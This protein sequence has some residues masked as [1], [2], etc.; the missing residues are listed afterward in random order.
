MALNAAVYPFAAL[1]LFAAHCLLPSAAQLSVGNDYQLLYSATAYFEM[2]GVKGTVAISQN[3]L[4][5]PAKIT[6]QLSGLPRQNV[7]NQKFDWEIHEYPVRYSLLRD[8]PCSAEE[9]GEIFD[10]WNTLDNPLYDTDCKN[11]RS[12]CAVGDLGGKVGYLLNTNT[13]QSFRYPGLQL[14]GPFSPVGRS[15]V[16]FYYLNDNTTLPLACANIER[17]GL[18]IVTLKATFREPGRVQGDVFLRYVD[19][20][21][22]VTIYADLYRLDGGHGENI[23]TLRE[24]IVPGACGVLYQVY[25]TSPAY[26]NSDFYQ[27]LQ[28]CNRTN[29][30]SCVIG[31]LTSKCGNLTTD[32]KGRMRAFC[33]DAQLGLIPLQHIMPLTLT[34]QNNSVPPFFLDCA[35]L[36][37][38]SPEAA[39]VLGSTNSAN[40]QI[41]V[42]LLFFQ[43][44]PYERTFIRSYYYY[45]RTPKPIAYLEIRNSSTNRVLARKNQIYL[46]SPL[47]ALKLSQGSIITGDEVPIGD[48][49]FKV[50]TGTKSTYRNTDMTLWLPLFGPYNITNH[51][52]VVKDTSNGVL[53]SAP[54]QRY[55]NPTTLYPSFMG[56]N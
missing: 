4:Y 11:N 25:G 31:D 2:N 28:N 51:V 10:P 44:D 55:D 37:V 41:F 30:R 15:I 17:Q 48:L 33:T 18:K 14:R 45:K 7:P 34:I 46:N 20:R 26:T 43:A 39:V 40:N 12:N 47:V 1:L 9:V 27:Y 5:D 38:V 23:W 22:E 53:L 42:N 13:L 32:S 8:F 21:S 49:Q 24:S 3:G 19:G 16:I 52:L 35:A 36:E 6:V 29:P 56:Y 54:I 50:P